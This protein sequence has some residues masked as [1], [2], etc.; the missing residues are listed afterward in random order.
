MPSDYE[1]GVEGATPSLL[2]S[3]I[4]QALGHTATESECAS[5]VNR[6][7]E[8]PRRWQTPRVLRKTPVYPF[9]QIP[10]LC[11]GVIVTIH[12]R[13]APTASRTVAG[14]DVVPS[15]FD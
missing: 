1:T 9:R 15:H 14:A 5:L 11:A 12:S 8:L 6:E 7:H 3:L 10:Q 4:R 2:P 13:K